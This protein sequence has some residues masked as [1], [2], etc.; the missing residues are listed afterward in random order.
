MARRM[1]RTALMRLLLV[2][3]IVCFRLPNFL[4]DSPK[5]SLNRVIPSNRLLGAMPTCFQAAF[6]HR[7]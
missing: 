3:E 4:L 6:N 7:A 1:V 2:N 5:G